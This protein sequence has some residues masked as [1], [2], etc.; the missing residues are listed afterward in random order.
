MCPILY[1]DHSFRNS[2]RRGNYPSRPPERQKSFRLSSLLL[3][4][5]SKSSNLLAR[6]LT[7]LA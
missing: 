2:S 7:E 3:H 5:E 4:D 1:A 6:D